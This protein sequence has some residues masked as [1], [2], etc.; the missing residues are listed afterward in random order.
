LIDD[1]RQGFGL[2]EGDGVSPPPPSAIVTYISPPPREN[3]SL[4]FSSLFSAAELYVFL[5]FF[6]RR[7]EVGAAFL[8]LLAFSRTV[9][10]F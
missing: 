8:F 4:F 9:I 7:A 6:P 5:G 10:R 2:P 3:Y 1:F